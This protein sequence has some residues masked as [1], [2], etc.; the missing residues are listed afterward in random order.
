MSAPSSEDRLENL[1]A[2]QRYFQLDSAI[3]HPATKSG[4]L[5]T[6]YQSTS[7]RLEEADHVRREH[8]TQAESDSLQTW[9]EHSHILVDS[10]MH[11]HFE[12]DKAVGSE[13]AQKEQLGQV[14]EAVSNE[15]PTS[16][17]LGLN[18]DKSFG[19][20]HGLKIL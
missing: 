5:A 18:I 4:H 3:A 7:N 8:L 9:H 2:N 15:L 1:K 20:K 17:M 19:Q 6:K 13:R 16:V 14:L 10:A 12:Q 11:L